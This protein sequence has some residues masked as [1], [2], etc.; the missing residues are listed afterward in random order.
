M[1][2]IEQIQNEC[3]QMKLKALQ[4]ARNAGGFGAHLGGSFSLMEMLA[5]LYN[6]ANWQ[7]DDETRDRIILSKGHGALALYTVLWQKGVLTDEELATFETNGT[8]YHT[9][10]K[11]NLQK[12]IEFSGGSLG[13]GISY[14]VGVAMACKKKGLNNRIFTIVG[15]GEMQEGIVWE[16]L[17]TAAHYQ[18]NNLTIIIDN[19]GLQIDGLTQQVMNI[20]PL[21]EKL[22]AFGFDVEQI[23]GHNISQILTALQRTST[24][25]QTIIANTRKGNGIS[26]LENQRQSHQYALNEKQYLQAIEDI[27]SYYGENN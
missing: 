7:P 11:R 20:Q 12:K 14:A 6:T 26:F 21:D 27:K 15:D 2:E 10:A 23:D 18:L 16:A 8:N 1:K 5:C 25:P 9:H 22:R 24:A 17:M 13:L 4:I 3:R 19:N